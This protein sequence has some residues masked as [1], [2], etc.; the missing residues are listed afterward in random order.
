MVEIL[1]GGKR[2]YKF[3]DGD[4][5]KYMLSEILRLLTLHVVSKLVEKTADSDSEDDASVY[6]PAE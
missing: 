2:K 6:C 4:E 3:C 1:C 5:Y